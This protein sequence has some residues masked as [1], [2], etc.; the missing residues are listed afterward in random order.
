MEFYISVVKII[1][2]IKYLEYSSPEQV[3]RVLFDRTNFEQEYSRERYREW[4]GSG[5]RSSIVAR[6]P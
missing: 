3:L 6:S 2:N 5:C 1:V 4:V